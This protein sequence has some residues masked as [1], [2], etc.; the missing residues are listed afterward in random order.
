MT[1]PIPTSRAADTVTSEEFRRVL[2][3][4]ATGIVAV[5]ALDAVGRPAALAVN[6]FASVSLRPP[7]VSFC[8]AETSRSWPRIRPAER[9]GISIL[10]D[11]QRP[12]CDRL[13]ASGP[14]KLHG[15]EWHLSPGGALLV[16]GATGWLEC[17]LRDEYWA[18]DH[19]IALCHV[20]HLAV[21][22]SD[23]PLLFHGGRYGTFRPGPLPVPR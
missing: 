21:G 12:V 4:F 10:A 6:S 18:G 2:G 14:D 1:D 20:H 17:S 13:A 11:R 5:A 3:R 15:T 9:I 23:A 16:A 7:L 22:E 8:V 19:V